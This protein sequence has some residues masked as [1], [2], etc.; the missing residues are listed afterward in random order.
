MII[1]G[2]GIRFGANFG[3]YDALPKEYREL[4]HRGLALLNANYPKM[5]E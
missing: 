5:G 3:L 1:N 4:T 2:V